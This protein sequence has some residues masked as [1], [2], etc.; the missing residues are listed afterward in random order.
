M[1]RTMRKSFGI[2]LPLP[3]YELLRIEATKNW[4]SMN[5][6]IEMRLDLSF[7]KDRPTKRFI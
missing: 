6:E 3:L 4:R 5:A 2:S 1:P 7:Q